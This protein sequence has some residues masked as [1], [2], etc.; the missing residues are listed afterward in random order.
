M[1]LK[2]TVLSMLAV[3]ALT[4]SVAAPMP[5]LAEGSTGTSTTTTVNEDGAFWYY[6]H[7][8]PLVWGNVDS[9]GVTTTV[10]WTPS[11]VLGAPVFWNNGYSHDPD[12]FALTLSAT[13][14]V[15]GGY[16]IESE[17]LS[18]MRYAQAYGNC[19][20][21]APTPSFTGLF[22]VGTTYPLTPEVGGNEFMVET[23]ISSNSRQSFGEGVAVEVVDA[24]AG[25]GCGLAEIDLSWGLSVPAGTY[26]GGDSAVYT[27]SVTL[28]ATAGG[29]P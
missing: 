21:N 16:T 11:D 5:V 8:E 17:N 26:T 23:W 29:T 13:D 3:A 19:S 15:S 14:L 22:N 18:V 9:P 1:N 24:T 4:I 10:N 12:G 6:L 7:P 28:T 25:R 2:K 20:V 27:G